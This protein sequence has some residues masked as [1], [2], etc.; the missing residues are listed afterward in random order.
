MR[1][2]YVHCGLAKTGTTSIQRYFSSQRKSLR[3]FGID[4]PK[5]GLNKSE[6]AHHKLSEQLNSRDEFD[7][8]AGPVGHLLRYMEN[9]L[10]QEKVVISSEGF[11]NCL[12]NRRARERFLGFLRASR[13]VNDGVF[14]VFRIRP[15]GQYFDSWYVQRLKSG[16]VPADIGDYV[17]DSQRWLKNY[18][19]SL[20][21]LK[22]TIGVEQIMMIDVH[23]GGGDAV[24]ALLSRVGVPSRV[25]DPDE[26]RFNERLGLKK[27]ALIYA[28]QQLAPS[29]DSRAAQELEELRTVIV[30]SD[31]IPND[32]YRYRVIPFQS[33][34]KIQ[35]AAHKCALPFIRPLVANSILPEPSFYDAVSLADTKLAP[36]DKDFLENS[37]SANARS[38]DLFESWRKSS[39]ARKG[40]AKLKLKDREPGEARDAISLP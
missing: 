36:E 5:I 35:Y 29:E 15:F 18:F 17:N 26:E 3:E 20:K 6:I 8:S 19:A 40:K 34:N 22:E 32:I 10:R 27:A 25:P 24:S 30:K 2:L 37:L 1:N 28:L 21:V 9:P 33:A 23:E 16:T 39:A 13:K 12:Y 11:A 7:I 38:T 14:V 31:E 4:Y